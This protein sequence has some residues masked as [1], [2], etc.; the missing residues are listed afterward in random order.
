MTISKLE[1]AIKIV[2]RWE[3][4]TEEPEPVTRDTIRI[5][6]NEW[7]DG[8]RNAGDPDTLEE[9]ERLLESIGEVPRNPARPVHPL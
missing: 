1:R 7:I 8:A 3:N 2:T 4:D 5:R 9:A 6:L